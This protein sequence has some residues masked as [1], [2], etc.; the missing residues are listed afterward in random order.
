M[1]STHHHSSSRHHHHHKHKQSSLKKESITF[2]ANIGLPSPVA[3][4]HKGSSAKKVRKHK[5]K[6][7]SVRKI[8]SFI[9]TYL[10][11]ALGVIFII[12]SIW[13]LY[14]SSTTQGGSL[15][16]NLMTFLFP[17]NNTLAGHTE[18]NNPFIWNIYIPYTFGFCLVVISAFI[19][20]IKPKLN[21]TLANIA[22]VY[23]N[24]INIKILY[25]DGLY[26]MNSCYPN[27][28]TALFI[29]LF[30]LFTSF[31]ISYYLKTPK[32][33]RIA[34]S[35]FYISLFLIIGYY[36]LKLRYLMPFVLLVTVSTYLLSFKQNYRPLNLW[37]FIFAWFF[38]IMIWLRKIVALNTSD[39]LFSFIVFSS[40]FYIL[41]QLI[42]ILN[43]TTIQSK[44]TQFNTILILSINSILLLS[45]GLFAFKRFEYQNYEFIFSFG[46]LLVNVLFL[47]FIIKNAI[48]ANLNYFYYSTLFLLSISVALIFNSNFIIIF[49]AIASISL[50][51]Y[52]KKTKDQIAILLSLGLAGL[53]FLL[54]LINWLFIYLPSAFS[55]LII[56]DNDILLRGIISGI[57]VVP[58]LFVNNQILKKVYISFSDDW[59][60]RDTIRLAIRLSFIF[61]LYLLLFYV[62]QY[63]FLSTIK[64]IQLSGL[65][66]Y[67]FNCIFLIILI[68]LAGRKVRT[69]FIISILLFAAVSILFYPLFVHF[70]IRDIRNAF[71]T[72]HELFLSGFGLHYAA[73]FLSFYLLLV[74][75]HRIKRKF[76]GNKIIFRTYYIFSSLIFLFFVLSEY[77]H[78]R[79]IQA[80][81]KGEITQQLAVNNSH[82]PY[83]ILLIISSLLILSVAFVNRFRFVRFIGIFVFSIALLK[84]LLFDFEVL[85]G[86]SK[87]V[88][89]FLLGAILIFLSVYYSKFKRILIIGRHNKAK[90]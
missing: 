24:I 50:L 32:I 29:S 64:T 7:S 55:G 2:D 57:F 58:I 28:N 43:N 15:W 11:L 17:T 81:R 19:K 3:I 88:V 59:F 23:L 21:I 34:I 68:Y 90:N 77:D 26:T 10:F 37:N 45:M 44:K 53:M 75:Y 25:Y 33:N 5:A 60:K 80:F 87:V 83:S 78:I 67:I 66:W 14:D 1:S 42:L 20:K 46:M 47:Y 4:V 79:F 51:I 27:H 73:V 54:F 6:K 72:N 65:S 70:S 48:K 69:I 8:E 40:L 86:T 30:L 85:N 38:I 52:S 62:F 71:I 22:I 13:W 61:S 18:V 49:S 41:S 12:G 35:F 74:I 31:V 39:Y 9:T 82:I 56:N 89:S 76:S 84:I 63:I 16:N 36:G